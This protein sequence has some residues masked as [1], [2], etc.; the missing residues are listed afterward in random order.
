[1]GIKIIRSSLLTKVANV[2][3]GFTTRNGGFSQ[4]PYASLNFSSRVGDK[5]EHVKANRQQVLKELGCSQSTLIFPKQV[6]GNAVF[7]VMHAASRVIEADGLWTR[8]RQVTLAVFTADCVPILISTS[9]GS[10]VAAIH[11]GWRG[12]RAHIAA[13]AVEKLVGAGY[14]AADLLV[15]VGPAIGPCCFEIDKNTYNELALAY[16]NHGGALYP[17]QFE[18][19]VA[20]LW[21]LNEQS[22]VAAGVV[23]SNIEKLK[24]CTKC[25]SNDFFSHRGENTPTGRQAAL[26]SPRYAIHNS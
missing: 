26:I 25:N 24:Y 12:T 5:I 20:N 6:H 4:K 11:A 21:I 14:A 13:R 10:A 8:D 15:A 3:H 16:P 1:M 2:A 9:D 22:L 17:N 19:Y 18:R 7:E 23:A